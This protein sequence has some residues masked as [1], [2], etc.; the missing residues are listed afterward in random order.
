VNN[1]TTTAKENKMKSEINGSGTRI[2]ITNRKAHEVF[3][4]RYAKRPYSNKEAAAMA[5][6]IASMTST[7]HQTYTEIFIVHGLK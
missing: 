5:W 1:G 3:S 6:E 7:P 2:E 4:E